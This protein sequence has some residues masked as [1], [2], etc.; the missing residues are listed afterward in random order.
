MTKVLERKATEEQVDTGRGL[1]IHVRSWRPDGAAR[2]VVVICHGVNSHS[3]YY[4]WVAEQL[5]GRGSPSMRSICMDA[6]CQTAIAST[7]NISATI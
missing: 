2:A 1:K 4:G 6:A 3:G 5:T 7:S